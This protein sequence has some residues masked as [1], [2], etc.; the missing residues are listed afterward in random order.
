MYV[1]PEGS[2]IYSDE[3]GLNGIEILENKLLQI[4]QK[5]P[6]ASLMLAGD[7]NN[8][9]CGYLQDLLDNDNI[10]FIFDDNG[11]YESDDFDIERNTKDLR[12]NIYIFLK[13]P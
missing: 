12:T 8:A 10:D 4:I 13:L 11:V 2:P 3:T 9:R 7:F 6:D 5:F 1:S